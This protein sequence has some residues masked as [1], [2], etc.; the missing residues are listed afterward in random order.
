MNLSLHLSEEQQQELLNLANQFNQ[1]LENP[2]TPPF[3]KA[4]T[5][6][7]FKIK[8]KAALMA[9]NGFDEIWN[10]SQTRSQLLCLS[11]EKT[12]IRNLPWQVATEERPLLAIAKS[13]QK[14]L[15]EHQVALGFPLK[16]LVMVASPEGVTRLAYEA[17]EL[18]LLR[19]FSPLIAEGLAQVHFTDDGSLENLEE[20][21]KEN[22]YHI[23]HF[24]GHGSY[25]NGQGTLALED[26]IS[27][28]LKSATATQFNEILARVRRKG[29]CP[30]LVVLSACQ[31][32]Q[33][34]E[35]GDLS[36]VAD[37]LMQGGI[38]SVIAMSA[39]ILDNCASLFAAKLY[40]ELSDGYPLAD[41][42]QEAR[43]AVKNFE[44]QTYNP[45]QGGYAAGQWLIPQL[46]LNQKVAELANK[47]A[48][49]T[50]LDFKND[51]AYIK[52]EKS[53]VDLR[54]RPKNYVF[55][56]RRKEKRMALQQLKAGKSIL[57]RGQG[58]VGK[59]A[60]AEHLAIRLLASNQRHKVFTF[61]EKKPVAQALLDQMQNYLTKEK[62]QFKV[63]SE[64]AIIPK[65][66][67]KF[68]HLLQKVSEVCDPIFLFD[69]IESFQQF[70]TEKNQWIWNQTQHIDV[71]EVMQVLDSQTPFPLII[72]GRYPLAEFPELTICNMNTVP[73]GDFF[74]K[75]YQLGFSEL[76]Q[77]M[78]TG[79]LPISPLKRD[80][81][82][83]PP[84]FEEVVRLL[85]KTFGGNYRALEFF[86]ELYTQKGEEI[87]QTL[88]Q[89]SN[90]AN[91]INEKDLK[92]GVLTRMSEN[93]IFTQLL[94]YLNA[95]ETD[96][97]FVLAQYNIPVLPMAI[98]MQRAAADRTDA[99][100]KLVN[101]TLAEAQTGSDGKVRFYVMPV[102]RDLL[103]EAGIA[104]GFE[105]KVAGDYHRFVVDERISEDAVGELKE[106]FECFFGAE[107]AEC[108]NEVGIWLC[109][110]YYNVQQFDMAY[111][112]G[113][114]I[115]QD[116][117]E[118]TSFRILNILGLILDIFGKYDLA[119]NYYEKSLVGSKEN[120]HR[121][122]EG[123]TF[124]NL[125]I[126]A[127]K[128]GDLKTALNYFKLT[129]NIHRELEFLEGE[130]TVL[131]NI[132]QIY[133]NR[134]DYEKSLNCL[135]QAIKIQAEINDKRNG[136][137]TLSNIGYI[138][139]LKGDYEKALSYFNK[140]LKVLRYIKDRKGEAVT[141]S[142][143][144]RIL[145][146]KGDSV[147]ALECFNNALN[148]QQQIGD[149]HGTATTLGN[150]GVMFFEKAKFEESLL[151]LHKSYQIFEGIG[152]P[153]KKS[154]AEYLAAILQ[155][156]GEPRFTQIIQSLK[157]K[158][159]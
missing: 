114:R 89:L 42:F 9:Q 126:S 20:K 30:E 31:T 76:A 17:E 58:G 103:E 2:A 109:N 142:N 70:D 121:Q 101:L 112:L 27:G 74:R 130:A 115:E 98:G 144:A 124:N 140:S 134:G 100:E 105:E 102:V 78:L 113:L 99:L 147:I 141:L 148:I 45:A 28:K 151:L 21:L 138:Y 152:S 41:A 4:T 81:N 12:E 120:K 26:P 43:Q 119:I 51:V 63:V 129:L 6:R 158:Q 47:N 62:K 86:D 94:T 55:I 146:L 139:Q 65:Q 136:G 10:S 73:F 29:H 35:A 40:A 71:L 34:V 64:L 91:K 68:F 15:S 33:G 110:F 83:K 84:T 49:K 125:A 80:K 14:N 7:D 127:Y 88:H 72:T 107:A 106:A 1:E 5:L 77:K 131:N 19:A 13:T 153:R 37:T 155:K 93:L 159:Q 111:K 95:E 32:A 143:I 97:L 36:G 16:A 3:P 23:L 57:L 39:S 11:H 133:Q 96:T 61:S 87:N 137:V 156:I 59:T 149:I 123:T 22:Q 66:T 60:L 18:Q 154:A 92:D 82:A 50:K 53:L 116:I 128:K 75:C 79:M 52:G 117:K 69:N 48:P 118:K 132:S 90:F 56:G 54:V 8:L 108:L 104:F 25:H 85:H 150:I 24:T 122:D 157:N 145:N 46:L 135:E 67:D 38:P 44:I